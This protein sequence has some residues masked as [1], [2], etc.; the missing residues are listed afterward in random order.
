MKMPNSIMDRLFQW[1]IKLTY[2]F[3]IAIFKDRI[4]PW[5][6]KNIQKRGL[7]QYKNANSKSPD[8]P[9]H[10]HSYIALLNMLENMLYFM[11]VNIHSFLI[12]S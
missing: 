9:A 2:P 3:D 7:N 4:F 6:K 1:K 10:P 12:S 5:K 11:P 8:Q